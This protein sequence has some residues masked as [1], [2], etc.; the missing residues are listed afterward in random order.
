[1]ATGNTL[2]RNPTLKR[3]LTEQISVLESIPKEKFELEF[4]WMGVD[5]MK[6][7]G[8]QIHVLGESGE[9]IERRISASPRCSWPDP[10]PGS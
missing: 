6:Q 8:K 1:V 9:V 5:G 4:G 3:T 7:E 2:L 10:E